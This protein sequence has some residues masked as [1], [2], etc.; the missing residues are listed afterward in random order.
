MPIRNTDTQSVV[1]ASL[2]YRTFV[3]NSSTVKKVV[4][5]KTYSLILKTM[6]KLM[7]ED[8]LEGH[9][10]VLPLRLGTIQ[11]TGIKTKPKFNDKGEL[12]LPVDWGST[13][14]MWKEHPELK[15]KKQLVYFTNDHTNG[16]R[17]KVK[18]SKQGVIFKNKIIY[19]FVAARANLRQLAQVIKNG[20]QYHY[21]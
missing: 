6:F 12:M 9:E 1:T 20:K 3:K 5:V 14:K 10:I 11:I 8:I 19:E 2:E 18:W 16:V 7:W 15:E 17:Y 4:D 13:N 21:E